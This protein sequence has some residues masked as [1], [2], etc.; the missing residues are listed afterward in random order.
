[1]SEIISFDTFDQVT[2][3]GDWSP[4]PTT[5]GVVLLLHSMPMDRKSWAPFQQ[6][7]AKHSIGSLAIDLRGHGE[8]IKV[9]DGE[10]LD[11]QKFTDAQHQL[12]LNDVQA[13][14]DWIVAKKYPKDRIF[15]VGASF[16][17]NLALWMLEEQP[18][19]AGAVLLSPGNYRGL[20]AVE[21]A[22]SITSRQVVWAAGSDTDDPEAYET[23]RLVVE[24]VASMRKVFQPYKNAGHGVHLF[25]S[26]PR[27]MENLASWLQET[28]QLPAYNA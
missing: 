25:K 4:A 23:A 28:L 2:I 21:I 13:A 5:L 17:A 22:D 6:V 24:R 12:C 11:Y 7:L 19:L 10:N 9:K 1:M 15:V 16:G 20:D 14:I 26:D 27:L 8:S 18:L 3:K